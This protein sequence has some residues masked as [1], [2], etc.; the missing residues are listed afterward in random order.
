VRDVAESKL[1]EQE[2]RHKAHHDHLTGLPNRVL[3]LDHIE[4]AVL[5]AKRN[6]QKLATLFLDLDGFKEINDTLGHDAGDLLLM[7]VARRLKI[8]TRSSD[9]AARMGGDEFT[10]VLNDISDDDNASSVAQKIIAELALPFVLEGEKCHIGGSIGISIYPA[11]ATD[12]ETLLKQ[13]D[14]AMYLAKKSGKN[15]YR[16][17]RDI[18]SGRT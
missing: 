16:F 11:D 17:Y 13:A 5:R 12:Y 14:E 6:Q 9:T 18:K 7:E 2:S 15:T 10:F 8:I 1:I 4:H 3:F